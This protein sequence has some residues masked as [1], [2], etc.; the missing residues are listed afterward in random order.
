MNKNNL[1][2]EGLS[3]LRGV[4]AISVLLFHVRGYMWIVGNNHTSA[5][6][7]FTGVFS[8]GATLFF[9]ISGFLMA[10]LIET[11]YRNFLVRRFARIYPTFFLAVG[12]SIFA[13]V[14]FLGTV[15]Q[16]D[17]IRSI[18]LL[19]FGVIPYP[20]DIE[21]TLVYEV[22]F[23]IVCAAFT[24][25]N[26]KR[27]FPY[28]LTLWLAGV[29]VARHGFHLESAIT[30]TI[31]TIPLQIFNMFFIVG[32]LTYYA[33]RRLNVPSIF[34][35]AIL[36]ACAALIIAW[37]FLER[38]P[39][40]AVHELYVFAACCVGILLS[41][42]ELSG[43]SILTRALAKAGDYSYG[44]YLIHASVLYIVL[45]LALQHFGNLPSAFA[46]A[47]FALALLA[48]I[49]MGMLD[50]RIHTGISAWIRARSVERV[51]VSSY[52]PANVGVAN[53]DG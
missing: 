26:A 53:S 13:K 7:I 10:H 34:A 3:S 48:G 18:S 8:L 47:G 36:A 23:Y 17:L 19:P 24:I 27:I 15:T 44:I 29:I 51:P 52:A 32:A 14:L 22:F 40:F 42:K 37:P 11:G 39:M 21:W 38:I 50:V 35:R 45:T 30:P 41:A 6:E 49:G 4:A 46:F 12:L 2:L 1:R 28:F 5:F 9:A 33:N 25:G 31:E 20:L 16:P 43:A